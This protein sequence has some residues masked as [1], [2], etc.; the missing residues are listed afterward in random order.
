VLRVFKSLLVAHDVYRVDTLPDGAS[1]YERDTISLG[2]ED[3][4]RARGRR[5]SDG[6]I[7]FGTAL[8]RGTVLTAGDCFVLDEEARVIAVV[9]RAEPLLIVEPPSPPEWGRF[10]YYIGNSHQPVMITERA[11]VCPDVPGMAQILEQHGI[12]FS[13][14]VGP[15]TPVRMMEDVFSPGHQ[16]APR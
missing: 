13:R 6:G 16:H 9:E 15:F 14:A 1:G 7:E 11:I 3:R 10:A 8:P 12:P 2:W 4:L 5:R